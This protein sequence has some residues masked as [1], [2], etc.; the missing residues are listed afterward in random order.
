MYKVLQNDIGEKCAITNGSFSNDFVHVLSSCFQTNDENEMNQ[1]SRQD[2]NKMNVEK[3]CWKKEHKNMILDWYPEEQ[4]WA[5][6]QHTESGERVCEIVPGNRDYFLFTLNNI[7]ILLVNVQ[8]L[9]G[10]YNRKRKNYKIESRKE[11]HETRVRSLPL[12]PNH[13]D[14]RRKTRD[15]LEYETGLFSVLKLYF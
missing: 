8:Q 6:L 10:H 12:S 2:D 7:I 3:I 11:E 9:N 5:R 4:C 13:S 1:N 14:K 15:D